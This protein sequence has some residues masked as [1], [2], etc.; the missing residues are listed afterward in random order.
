MQ[1]LEDTIAGL[2]R[3]CIGCG[4]CTEHCPSYRHGGLDP[5]EM[6]TSGKGDWMSCSKTMSGS[7]PPSQNRL[8]C[9]SMPQ[10]PCTTPSAAD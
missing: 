5:H 9:A 8:R 3:K 1:C 10:P 7:L 6:M 4:L 2:I